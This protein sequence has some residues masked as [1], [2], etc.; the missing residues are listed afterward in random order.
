[1]KTTT[2][3]PG[4]WSMAIG[5]LPSASLV[6]LVLLAGGCDNDRL[7]DHYRKSTE[8]SALPGVV[9]KAAEQALPGVTFSDA[10]QNLN[11]K[12]RALHSYEIRGRNA[13]GKVREVRVSTTGEILELE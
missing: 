13:N 8:I 1:M 6:A 9:R 10:W 11:S 12:T 2:L 3:K 5:S 7:P 4:G